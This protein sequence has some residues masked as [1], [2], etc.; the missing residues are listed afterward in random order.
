MRMPVRFHI[1]L[2]LFVAA[3][4]TAG[5]R[6]QAPSPWS[7]LPVPGG[8]VT[9][10][11]RQIGKVVTY[12]DS[13]Q[14]HAYS[15]F[16]HRWVSVAA[17]SGA[18][19]RV[20][21]D[22]ALVIDGNAFHAFSAYTGRWSLK[23]LS[24]GAAVANPANQQNDSIWLV[25]DGADLWAFS[26]FRGDWVRVVVGGNAAIQVERHVALVVDGTTLHAMSALHGR[27]VTTTAS[28]PPA[29]SR[30][31][32]TAAV[33]ASSTTVHG[34]SALSDA[35]ASWPSPGAAP[36]LTVHDDTQVISDGNTHVGFSGLRGAFAQ[37]SLPLVVLAAGECV[38]VADDGGGQRWVYSSVLNTWTSLPTAVVATVSVGSN[39]VLLTLAD[40]VH[41]FSAMTG[42]ITTAFAVAPVA[43]LSRSVASMLAHDGSIKFYSAL[44]GQ[45]FDAPAGNAPQISDVAGFVRTATGL[46]AF[47]SRTG[48]FTS[49]AVSQAAQTIIGIGNA[50]QAVI[51]QSTLHVFDP[52]R[53]RWLSG[54]LQGIPTIGTHRSTLLVVDTAQ[55]WGYGSF[56]GR[57]T[58]IALPGPGTIGRPN[59]ESGSLEVANALMA[60][61]SVPD[62]LTLWQYPEFRR[63]Y[64]TGT[65]M[66]VQVQGD[67]GA[68]F[69]FLS[70]GVLQSPIAI[71]GLGDLELDPTTL[72][73][74]S[75]PVAIS[76]ARGVLRFPVPDVAA[77]RGLEV[78]FQAAVVPTA[79]TPYLTQSTSVS[80][81]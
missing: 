21:N 73:Q 54:A 32:G 59:S 40:R 7:T 16:A 5:A 10:N 36:Q 19:I 46:S 68:A 44:L 22:L 53:E 35:W 37:T 18:T 72:L 78:C 11:L 65:P 63:V 70:L 81:F 31:R 38:C 14:V 25:R 33:A 15:A 12:A 43:G 77:L 28:T 76:Q 79:G 48:R 42:S 74:G 69:V 67:D 23:T 45:W 58:P 60:H 39:A 9:A 27:W 80:T 20:A 29:V 6:G 62:L 55:A 49:L 26:A 56:S 57:L 2:S 51:D 64:V 30:A 71:P 17:S 75:L 47:S 34:F 24:P 1:S 8:V 66:E 41:A 61:S 4:L 50:V 3:S 13:G 52:R